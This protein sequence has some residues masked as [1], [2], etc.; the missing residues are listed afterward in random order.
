VRYPSLGIAISALGGLGAGLALSLVSWVPDPV[1]RQA[2]GVDRAVTAVTDLASLRAELEEEYEA[3]AELAVMADWLR[4]QLGELRAQPPAAGRSTREAPEQEM[5]PPSDSKTV[6]TN[7][8]PMP[9]RWFDEAS[10][11]ALGVSPREIQR[12]RERFEDAQLEELQLRDEATRDGWTNSARYFDELHELWQGVRNDLGDEAYDHLLHASGR[13]NRVLVGAVSA[14]SPA[15]AAGLRA[16]DI[17]LRYD[18]SAVFSTYEL[19]VAMDEG[20]DA[21]VPVD[22]LRGSKELRVWVPQRLLGARLHYVRR[23][24][25]P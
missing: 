23:S 22:V 16:G 6:G 10:L 21:S 14:G 24:L 3:Q 4:W 19:R 17:I 8:A 5:S 1:A 12:L 15:E 13:N 18:G 2:A 9:G 7:A 25:T 11:E 20:A